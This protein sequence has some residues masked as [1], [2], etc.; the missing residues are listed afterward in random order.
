[1]RQP[2]CKEIIIVDDDDV[3]LL[4]EFDLF[5]TLAIGGAVGVEV[6]FSP[7]T[8]TVKILDDD[9]PM[10][11]PTPPSEPEPTPMES[12]TGPMESPTG[13]MESP[14]GPMEPPTQQPMP[15]PGKNKE[16]DNHIIIHKQTLPISVNKH[17]GLRHFLTAILHIY[18]VLH[19]ITID[20]C[21][22]LTSHEAQYVYA[23]VFSFFFV[24]SA[25]HNIDIAAP[26]FGTYTN[27]MRIL[28]TLTFISAVCPPPTCIICKDYASG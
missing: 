12:P 21:T 9:I 25:D 19:S 13:P 24:T 3:E 27:C 18:Q 4:E 7:I 23:M 5:L 28:I 20:L 15:S 14:T 22:L 16:Q 1:M 11:T 10:P 6:S 8:T 26:Q 2:L 17:I